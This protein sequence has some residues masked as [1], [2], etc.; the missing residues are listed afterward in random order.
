MKYKKIDFFS[1]KNN[2]FFSLSCF[3]LLFFFNSSY[4]IIKF[5]QKITKL[6]KT[7]LVTSLEKIAH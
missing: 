6:E 5:L 3:F 7:V 2:S 4:I 1:Q